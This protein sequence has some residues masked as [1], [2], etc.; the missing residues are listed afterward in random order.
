MA[1]ASVPNYVIHR[2]RLLVCPPA[3]WS[4]RSLRRSRSF[5]LSPSRSYFLLLQP[6]V[7]RFSTT[8]RYPHME[9][10]TTAESP[11][12]FVNMRARACMLLL[13]RLNCATVSFSSSKGTLV[14]FDV[15]SRVHGRRPHDPTTTIRLQPEKKDDEKKKSKEADVGGDGCERSK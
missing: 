15:A 11:D 9:S 3:R 2:V 6:Y 13:S 10:H 14:S 1:A 7:P 5:S 12:A 8:T 4:R